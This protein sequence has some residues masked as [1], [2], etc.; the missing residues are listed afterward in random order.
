M[1]DDEGASRELSVDPAVLD[2]IRGDTSPWRQSQEADD[3]PADPAIAERRDEAIAMLAVLV[4]TKLTSRQR[5]IIDF[6]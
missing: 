2:R 1:G 6:E 3:A 4:R 5:E